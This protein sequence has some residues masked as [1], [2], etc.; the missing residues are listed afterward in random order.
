MSETYA[1]CA[2]P[3]WPA[4]RGAKNPTPLASWGKLM[5]GVQTVLG[6]LART[7]DSLVRKLTFVSL[8]L[9]AVRVSGTERVPAAPGSGCRFSPALVALLAPAAAF[10]APRAQLQVHLLPESQVG[11]KR[12]VASRIVCVKGRSVAKVVGCNPCA[13]T[14][15]K[16]R[17]SLHMDLNRGTYCY[18]LSRMATGCNKHAKTNAH[19]ASR[20]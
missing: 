16:A 20:V 11:D 15:G 8:G 6:L 4:S 1:G 19:D 3:S 17:D 9:L 14:R 7:V 13:W 5:R 2:L 10:L 12:S 18:L